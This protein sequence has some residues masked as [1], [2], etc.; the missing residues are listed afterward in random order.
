[1]NDTNPV[2]YPYT[3]M[4]LADEP[5]RI[6]RGDGAW[7][8]D[9][10]GRKLLDGIS[11]WWVNIHGHARREI[12]EAIYRQAT[13]LEHVVFAG[14]T[15]TP[16]VTLAETLVQKCG[17]PDWKVFYSDNGSTAVEVALK[18][19]IQFYAN[20][21]QPRNKILCWQNC[22]HGETFGAMSVSDQPVF[23]AAF[24]PFLFDTVK[25]PVPTISE[26]EE[27]RQHLESLLSGGEYAAFIYEPLV[28]GTGGMLMYN[29]EVLDVLVTTCR[30][31]GTF[32]IADEVMTGF[33]RTGRLLAHEHAAVKPDMICLAKG[34]TGGFL[35]LAVTLCSPDIFRGFYVADRKKT[36]F[37]G[38]SYTAN[39]LGC[40]AALASLQLMEKEDFLDRISMIQQSFASQAKRL[41]ELY[42]VLN[43]RHTGCIFALDLPVAEGGYFSDIGAEAA[44]FFR[45]KE[46]LIRPL[47]NVVYFMP[48]YV[49]TFEEIEHFFDILYQWLHKIDLLN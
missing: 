34:L 6:T 18:M 23:N 42:A 11:S 28:Q 38:H 19:A 9:S 4:A 31:Y 17:L 12:A 33:Y 44:R 7:L 20:L 26:L 47:G 8:Y 37:H 35:P 32:C 16:A 49:I 24:G 22:F 41:R 15:H 21:G 13:T 2:W 45:E 10:T 30:R 39:P 27:F 1:M 48:P 25:I 43:A 5:V 29:A 36:L 3:Q 40:A 14:Y 46:I